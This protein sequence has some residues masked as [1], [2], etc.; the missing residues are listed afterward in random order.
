MKLVPQITTN[1]LKQ[2][3]SKMTN[4][5]AQTMVN[6]NTT[7]G[8]ELILLK[9]KLYM[10]SPRKNP[11]NP[12]TTKSTIHSFFE[13]KTPIAIPRMTVTA[14]I[15]QNAPVENTTCMFENNKNKSKKATERTPMSKHKM[16]KK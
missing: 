14:M 10:K 9:T 12:P 8:L 1:V 13:S 16:N 7:L 5:I 11:A 4:A 6:Q 2:K 15:A 3:T